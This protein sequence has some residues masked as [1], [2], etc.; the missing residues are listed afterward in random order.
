MSLHGKPHRA[1]SKFI[2]EVS[3][4]YLAGML[5][6]V[7]SNFQGLRKKRV[8]GQMW[9]FLRKIQPFQGG[10]PVTGPIFH[11]TNHDTFGFLSSTNRDLMG[12]NEN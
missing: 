4:I 2:A 6:D 9:C 11:W 7:E 8:L 12:S 1:V 10:F 5:K 3:I